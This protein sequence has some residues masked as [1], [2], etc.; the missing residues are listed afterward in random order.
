MICES[1]CSNKLVCFCTQESLLFLQ[2]AEIRVI[3]TGLQK[4]K[5]PLDGS[6]EMQKIIFV[7]TLWLPGFGHENQ[8]STHSSLKEAGQN[9]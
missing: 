3:A 6:K 9:W 4:S 1:L 7:V 5:W 2:F 8:A